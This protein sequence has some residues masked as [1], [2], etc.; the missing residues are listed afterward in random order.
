MSD[1]S[2]EQLTVVAKVGGVVIDG[3]TEFAY[4]GDGDS[5]IV[6]MLT[7][8]VVDST[9]LES[10][11]DVTVTINDDESPTLE[12]C[13]GLDVVGVT[14][15]GESY[16]TV[17]A[18]TSVPLVYPTVSDNSGE[19]LTVV[20]KVGGV[21]I[22]ESTEF[23]YVGDG[24]TAVVTTLTYAVVDSTGLESTCDVTVTIND[25]ESPTLEDCSGLDVVGVTDDGESYGTV[26][27]LRAFQ[28]VYP[29]VSD[30]SG[31]LLTVVA[32]VGGVVIDGSTE[33][34]YV[35]D[36]ETAV[37]TTLTYAVVDSAGLESTCDVTVTINDDES[38]TLEDC[39][40]LD[41]VGVT[42]DGESYGTLGRFERSVGVSDGERQLWGGAHGCC[43]GWWRGD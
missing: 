24:E 36:G 17:G 8:A 6:T 35:G 7:Y 22:D 2:G 32:K 33:F 26:G 25:D 28:L 37:V 27:A 9:G 18:L 23:A 21:V 20:A 16:G 31:E 14:D 34:P 30:N 42:D 3:S 12:D 41:V 1:N 13:S 10:T 5:A 40:G 11:C 38:P 29:T 4:V 19:V 39:G 43:E 15:D